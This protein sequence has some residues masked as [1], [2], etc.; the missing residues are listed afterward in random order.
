MLTT[1]SMLTRYAVAVLSVALALLMTLLLR[2]WLEQSVFLFFFPAVM[3][4]AWYG[5]L[6]LG[7]AA[8]LLSSLII[9]YFLL[10]PPGALTIGW[11]EIPRML[12]FA[13]MAVVISSFA[14]TRRRSEEKL[15]SLTEE[16]KRNNEMKSALL[17]SV[18]HDL[19][20]PL[21]SIRAAVD[22]LLNPKLDWDQTTLREFHLIIGEEAHR[23]TKL[24]EDL[25]EMARIEAGELRLLI[26]W[27]SVAEIC[28]YALDQCATD[29]CHHRVRADYSEDLPQVKVDAKLLAEALTHIIENA[30]RYSP[31]GSE[32]LLEARFDGEELR[33][34]VTDQGLGI[35]PEEVES[36]FEKFYRGAHLNG[37]HNDGTGMGLAITR[38]LVEAHGGRVWV[39]NSSNQ[40]PNRGATFT[41]A[42]RAERKQA[43]KLEV[44][45]D[46]P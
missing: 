22:N 26:K 25:M 34:S 32:I 14:E 3:V 42:L 20:T 15:R 38:G 45:G 33:L 4:S 28:D 40:G 6:W 41:I 8:T 21:T 19:R 18:S 12:M 30:A 36:I 24:I 31:E 43:R 11:S 37:R 46:E 2:P 27:G 16:L 1:H 35:A 5:G 9:D 23:L 7:L 17:A 39:E 44:L 29:L 10:S 13:L